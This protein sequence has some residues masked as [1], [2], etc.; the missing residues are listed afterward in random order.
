MRQLATAGYVLAIYVGELEFCGSL[1]AKLLRVSYSCLKFPIIA[2]PLFLGRLYVK[3]GTKMEGYTATAQV[4]SGTT[5]VP[6]CFWC[7]Q[8]VFNRSQVFELRCFSRFGKPST[9]LP[10]DQHRAARS[11]RVARYSSCCKSS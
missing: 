6:L 9:R 10:I 7:L 8:E 3:S 4:G 2:Q 5:C 11:S 1:P